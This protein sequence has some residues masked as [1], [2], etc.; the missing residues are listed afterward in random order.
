MNKFIQE[1]AFIRK[2]QRLALESACKPEPALHSR[3]LYGSYPPDDPNQA[4]LV[5]LGQGRAL[6][7]GSLVLTTANCLVKDAYR[8]ARAS[9]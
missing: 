2:M 8:P 3:E 6:L 7:G 1:T 9:V 5:E 4:P